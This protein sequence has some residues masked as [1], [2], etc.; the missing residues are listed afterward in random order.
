MPS[1][2]SQ[3]EGLK[4]RCAEQA[5]N[6]ELRRELLKASLE[7][8]PIKNDGAVEIDRYAHSAPN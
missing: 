1:A 7:D 5:K 2:A 6:G 8:Y 3:A 4:V